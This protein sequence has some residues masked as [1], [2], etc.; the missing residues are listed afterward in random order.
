[1]YITDD[2]IADFNRYDKEK[3]EREDKC[4]HCHDCGEPIFD[5]YY[6]FDGRILCTECVRG[7]RKEVR[8]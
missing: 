8:I 2:P 7:Y 5:E 6:E 4:P 3:S 1:M